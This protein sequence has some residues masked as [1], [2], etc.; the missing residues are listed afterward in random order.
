MKVMTELEFQQTKVSVKSLYVN[1]TKVSYQIDQK[2]TRLEGLY[3][4]YGPVECIRVVIWRG[5]IGGAYT[6]RE[7]D[8]PSQQVV[9][10]VSPD[11]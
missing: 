7:L 8:S 11:V 4:H 2:N 9:W 1:T 6:I 5:K 3:G 10:S